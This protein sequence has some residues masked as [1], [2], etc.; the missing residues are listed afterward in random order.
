M[1]SGRTV[2]GTEMAG[3]GYING[4]F[5]AGRLMEETFPR[6]RDEYPKLST[7]FIVFFFQFRTVTG[8]AGLRIRI[9]LKLIWH[10]ET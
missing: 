10:F 3:L 2:T 5:L 1:P 8:R 6:I 4:L 9:H 7:Y